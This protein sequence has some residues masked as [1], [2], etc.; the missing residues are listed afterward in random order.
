MTPLRHQMH[1]AMLVRGFAQ[2]TRQAYLEV[3]AKLAAFYHQS[4]AELAP[5]QVE[6]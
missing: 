1:D 2:R 3:V 4:P 6:A 5:E